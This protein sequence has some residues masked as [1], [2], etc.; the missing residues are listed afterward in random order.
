MNKND[1]N[2]IIKEFDPNSIYLDDPNS[3][4]YPNQ[5]TDAFKRIDQSL[6]VRRPPK[7]PWGKIY[8]A[9]SDKQKIEYLEKFAYSMNNAAALVQAE[10]DELNRLTILKEKQLIKLN[11]NVKKNN[12]MLQQ[13]VTRMN[14]QRQDYNKTIAE[15]GQEIRNLKKQLVS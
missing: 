9:K 2:G 14:T 5:E 8:L 10:R 4:D 1:G 12:A 15:Q 3:I 7:I 13:E 11:D 6:I